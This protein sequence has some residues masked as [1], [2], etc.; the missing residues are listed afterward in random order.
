MTGRQ[1]V[2]AN[3]SMLLVGEGHLF[4]ITALE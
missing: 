2:D 1:E 3:V 4:P